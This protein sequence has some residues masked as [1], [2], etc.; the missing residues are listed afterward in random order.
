MC[1]SL[2]CRKCFYLSFYFER[3]ATRAGTMVEARSVKI[4]RPVW[5][6]DKTF[7]LLKRDEEDLEIN[8][9]CFSEPLSKDFIFFNLF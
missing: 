2:K 3:A 1:G 5:L 4:P 8:L 6:L 7:L 9:I